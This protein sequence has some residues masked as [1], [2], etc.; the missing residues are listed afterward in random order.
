MEGS[1]IIEAEKV[2]GLPPPPSLT[3]AVAVSGKRKSKQLVKWALEKFVPEGNAAFKLLHV[4]PRIISVPTPSK[5]L[6][7]RMMYPNSYKKRKTCRLICSWCQSF[8]T[9][10]LLQSRSTVCCY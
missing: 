7:F 4:R 8:G 9:E 2:L 10:F 6:L 3:V 5:M 1:K